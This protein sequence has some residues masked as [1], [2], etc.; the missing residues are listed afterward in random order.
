MLSHI[1]YMVAQT[2]DMLSYIKDMAL[3]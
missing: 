1:K 2:K 3:I